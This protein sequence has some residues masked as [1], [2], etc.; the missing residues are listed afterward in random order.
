MSEDELHAGG[1][2][3]PEGESGHRGENE[4]LPDLAGL[5][6]ALAHPGAG[7]LKPRPGAGTIKPKPGP[8]A[9]R[10]RPVAGGSAPKLP[11]GTSK[12]PRAGGSA[13]GGHAKVPGG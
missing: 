3:G 1:P 13:G 2:V 4:A 10:A 11:H 5:L 8:S 7:A 9:S 6:D 12:P